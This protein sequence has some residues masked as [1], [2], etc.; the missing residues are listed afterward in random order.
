MSER[1]GERREK[2]LDD[3]EETR[4]C[5]KLIEEALDRTM[6]RTRFEEAVDLSQY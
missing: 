2:L 3:L 5:W 1:R 6:W 4:G